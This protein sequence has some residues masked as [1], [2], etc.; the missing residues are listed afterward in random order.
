MTAKIKIRKHGEFKEEDFGKR[1]FLK[2]SEAYTA[3]GN[4]EGYSPEFTSKLIEKYTLSRAVRN[5]VESKFGIGPIKR[6]VI[7]KEIGISIEQYNRIILPSE[8]RSEDVHLTSIIKIAQFFNT[9]I[10]EIMK[11]ASRN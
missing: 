7:E 2:E 8:Y 5:L 9:T 6:E 3:L 1:I 11:E 10:E 4:K